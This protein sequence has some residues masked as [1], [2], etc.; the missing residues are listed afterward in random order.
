VTV[1]L[2]HRFFSKKNNSD[3]IYF[4]ASYLKLKN[5]EKKIGGKKKF[6]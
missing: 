6:L 2:E 3:W 5:L 4:G 1:R